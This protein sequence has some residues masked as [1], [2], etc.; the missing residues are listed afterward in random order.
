MAERS[1][2]LQILS[3]EKLSLRLNRKN[4]GFDGGIR[5]FLLQRDTFLQADSLFNYR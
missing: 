2:T 3:M 1:V 4:F 5:F